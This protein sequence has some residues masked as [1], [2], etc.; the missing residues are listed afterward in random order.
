[1]TL[2]ARSD[3]MSVSIPATSGGCGNTH[4]RPVKAGVPAR[5]WGLDCPDCETHLRGDRKMKIIRTIPGDKDRGIP[6][7][8]EH[9]P[10]SDPHWSST[11]EA[12]PL[13]PDEQHVHKLRAEQGK[14][15]LDMLSAYASLKQGGI[16]IPEQAQWLINRTL[17]EIARPII[18]GSVVCVNGHD[19]R[20]GVKFC[21]ECGTRMEAKGAIGFAPPGIEP[22]PPEPVPLED[23]IP[24]QSLHIATLRKRCR[25]NN[26]SDKGTKAQLISRLEQLDI[27]ELYEQSARVVQV[28]RWSPKG[29]GGA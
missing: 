7:R 13:T 16:D 17:E 4:S 21:G 24:L 1:M 20:A 19:N 12:V 10:D 29:Q 6:S 5:T 28:L 26:L 3:L 8:L 15:Q 18:K 9:I 2:Y 27:P 11:P 22:I 14:Q 25:M 23:L